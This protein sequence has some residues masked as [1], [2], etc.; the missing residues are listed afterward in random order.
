MRCVVW[1]PIFRIQIHHHGQCPL[2]AEDQISREA[3]FIHR[4]VLS[5]SQIP[6]FVFHWS[7]KE[8]HKIEMMAPLFRL[9][10]WT[11]NAQYYTLSPEVFSYNLSLSCD[12]FSAEQTTKNHLHTSMYDAIPHTV[13]AFFKGVS[14]GLHELYVGVDP[15]SFQP[16]DLLV[17]KFGSVGVYWRSLLSYSQP[18][19]IRTQKNRPRS[20][21]GCSIQMRTRTGR[22]ISASTKPLVTHI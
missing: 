3:T 7:Y 17:D 1:V 4:P 21:R 10:R 9:G 12:V 2:L 5:H 22:S 20:S 19:T 6:L 13:T 14:A 18:L 8:S 11:F 15:L 16:P